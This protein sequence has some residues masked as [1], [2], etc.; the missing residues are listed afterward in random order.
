MLEFCV[1]K[2]HDSGENSYAWCDTPEVRKYDE[3]I[4]HVVVNA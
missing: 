1:E 3:V 2:T 4:K